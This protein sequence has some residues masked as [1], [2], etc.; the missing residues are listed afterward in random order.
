MWELFRIRREGKKVEKSFTLP[1]L[2]RR[3]EKSDED[4]A[5]S[6]GSP[7][8]T[9]VFTDITPIDES[10]V[11]V[12]EREDGVDATSNSERSQIRRSDTL[13]DSGTDGGPDIS[14][15]ITSGRT[16]EVTPR[17]YKCTRCTDVYVVECKRVNPLVILFT[18]P[19][20]SMLKWA[21]LFMTSCLFVVT[22]AVLW[23]FSAGIQSSVTL[24]GLTLGKSPA[25]VYALLYLCRDFSERSST[26]LGARDLWKTR[27][28]VVQSIAGRLL[29]WISS[30]DDLIHVLFWEF[31]PTE[32]VEL[33]ENSFADVNESSTSVG[34]IRP[35]NLPTS[36]FTFL[37]A[38]TSTSSI[39][40]PRMPE[41]GSVQ[42]PDGDGNVETCAPSPDDMEAVRESALSLAV[43]CRAVRFTS[44]PLVQKVLRWMWEGRVV[45]VRGG[46]ER[47]REDPNED[48]SAAECHAESWLRWVEP[49]QTAEYFF[50][51]THFFDIDKLRVPK[52]QYLYS[53][54]ATLLFLLLFTSLSFSRPPALSP[55]ELVCDA[56]AASLL[57]DE[58]AALWAGGVAFYFKNLWN[59]L[60][61]GIFSSYVA[62][63]V[64]RITSLNSADAELTERAFD[65]LAIVNIFLWPR[66]LS[67]LDRYKFFGTIAIIVKRVIAESYLYIVLLSVFALGF[68]Q[69]MYA[70]SLGKQAGVLCNITWD[71][72]DFSMTIDD[73]IAPGLSLAFVA[74]VGIILLNLLISIFN[75]SFS[76]IVASSDLEFD[77]QLAYQAVEAQDMSEPFPFLPPF[78][79]L[80]P[81]F[82]W[83]MKLVLPPTTYVAYNL[84]LVKV[85]GIPVLIG[86]WFWE[87]GTFLGNKLRLHRSNGYE[88]L[89][90][91]ESL[92]ALAPKKRK[93]SKRVSVCA[94]GSAAL[95]SVVEQIAP[96]FA[97]ER[98]ESIVRNITFAEPGRVNERVEQILEE[99]EI[100]SVRFEKGGLDDLIVAITEIVRASEERIQQMLKRAEDRMQELEMKVT[101]PE[102]VDPK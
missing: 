17:V 73:T 60:D 30:P 71:I 29:K 38:I 56:L 76:D 100:G 2:L 96:G 69:A 24:A 72:L 12:E 52:Y 15:I 46:G 27:A 82:V 83:P 74:T 53:L 62:F 49:P 20:E 6:Q 19:D 102:F 43:D 44:H 21:T 48:A 31:S 92:A 93:R 80:E 88:A 97:S 68:L 64:M 77:F 61:V 54:A 1:S 59:W 57:M 32:V 78:N 41:F 75:K 99:K 65:V 91:R 66:F 8:T 11:L 79:L 22:G 95:E 37:D 85:C 67:I 94:T 7:Q 9:E 89:T 4:I 18:D 28:Q 70:L 14:T 39:C 87:A 5:E 90:S 55:L 35:R 86:V 40:L 47:P 13:V 63:F 51:A 42:Y 101:K 10:E 26:D 84:S 50:N 16:D 58:L 33:A 25:T 45:V 81:F 3:R 36:S 34:D 98:K 23:L